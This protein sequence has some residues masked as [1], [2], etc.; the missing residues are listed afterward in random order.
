MS[1]HITSLIAAGEEN[2][3]AMDEEHVNSNGEFGAH[4][5]IIRLVI[6]PKECCLRLTSGLRTE[7]WQ[8]RQ[9]SVH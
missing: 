9:I 4:D 6:Y 5:T 7:I 1:I 3:I 8:A 2:L